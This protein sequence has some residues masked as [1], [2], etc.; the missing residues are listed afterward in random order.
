MISV[1]VPIYKVEKYLRECID[2]IIE[3]TYRDLDI[4][5][6]DD[7]SPDQCG[8]LCDDYASKDNRI[9]VI[10][11]ENGG[12]SDAR[13]AGID[14]AEG[15][16]L[17]FVDS[18]DYIHPQM[19]ERL[20]NTML[21]QRADIVVCG[22]REVDEEGQQLKDDKISD[23]DILCYEGPDIMDQ[24]QQ[25]NLITVVAWNKLYSASLFE[26][27]RY[28]K[29]HVHEDEFIIHRILGKCKKTVYIP[30]LL[31]YYRKRPASI[32]ADIDIV[33]IN[34]VIAAYEDRI[35]FLQTEGYGQILKDTKIQYCKL[36]IKY[37]ER[38]R[39]NKYDKLQTKKIWR[40]FKKVYEDKKITDNLSAT[41]KTSFFMFA[42]SPLLYERWIQGHS[43]IEKEKDVFR[44]L[45]DR[46]MKK[47]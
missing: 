9:R 12:L 5:L 4:I 19:I 8:K 24:L 22:F 31:Y 47:L 23:V 43:S 26:N 40:E 27:I 1:I 18:D 21:T 42:Q 46:I 35:V 20:Y 38:L 29:G 41:E 10:H 6:V 14:I 44:K 33:K 2:S 11:K 45:R 17:I 39:K 30:D 16:Y 32:M 3:Q 28:P 37:T 34:D 13:K 15:E 25:K 36:L 7:G